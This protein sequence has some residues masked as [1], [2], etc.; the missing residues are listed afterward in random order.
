MYHQ[1]YDGGVPTVKQRINL[2]VDDSL[3]KM[4][5]RLRDFKNASSISAVVLELTQS[6]LEY[7][8]D[9]FLAE[10]ADERES[11]EELSHEE[12]WG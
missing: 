3:Y 8:E 5:E 12:I 2:T 10:I 11:E 9:L 6:A 4:L 7:E 1:C